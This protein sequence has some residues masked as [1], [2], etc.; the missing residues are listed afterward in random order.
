MDLHA[1]PRHSWRYISISLID[2][3]L[4]LLCRCFVRVH[5]FEVFFKFTLKCSFVHIATWLMKSTIL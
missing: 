2:G 1:A 4:R 5:A 3:A